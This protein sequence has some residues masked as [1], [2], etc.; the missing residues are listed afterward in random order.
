MKCGF[1]DGVLFFFSDDKTNP[2]PASVGAHAFLTFVVEQLDINMGQNIISIR[3][4][5]LVCNENSAVRSF[6]VILKLSEPRRR[7]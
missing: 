7:M 2:R 6:S 3:L 4:R 5:V 1:N